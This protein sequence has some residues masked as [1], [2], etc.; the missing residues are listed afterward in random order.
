MKIAI[1]FLLGSFLCAG[2][3]FA[4]SWVDGS[5]RRVDLSGKKITIKHGAIEDIGM[6]PMTMVFEVKNP[7]WLES[8]KV[9][10]DIRFQV[11]DLGGGKLRVEALEIKQR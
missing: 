4:Q 8:L 1:S 7:Q 2:T 3:V 5:V 11:K 6:P 10:D 9:R